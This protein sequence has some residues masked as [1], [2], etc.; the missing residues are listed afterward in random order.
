MNNE[1][2]KIKNKNIYTA[3]FLTLIFPFAGMLNVGQG[4]KSI[5][6]LF[7]PLLSIIVGRGLMHLG[8]F[9]GLNEKIIYLILFLIFNIFPSAYCYRLLLNDNNVIKDKWYTKWY[10]IFLVILLSLTTVYSF[11][12]L[13]AEPYRVTGW[14]MEPTLLE[15]MNVVSIKPGYNLIQSLISKRDLKK[16]FYQKEKIVI[17]QA[18]KG[19]AKPY[20]VGR[21]IGIGGDLIEVKN[22]IVYINGFTYFENKN[23]AEEDNT[24]LDNDGSYMILDQMKILKD[25]KTVFTIPKGYFLVGL[26]KYKYMYLI[27]EKNLYGIIKFIIWDQTKKKFVFRLIN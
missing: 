14:G 27:P 4:K 26:I 11:R 22:N 21:I 5:F 17:Y 15:G 13:I 1:Y 6:F 20:Q 23:F 12:Q 16:P 3:T 8:L 25:E 9:E 10:N 18:I 2:D 7:I 19:F 24:N